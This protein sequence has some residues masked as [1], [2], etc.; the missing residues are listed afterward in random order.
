MSDLIIKVVFV[1]GG[2]LFSLIVIGL[3]LFTFS[4]L[5]R[6]RRKA[7]IDKFN[8]WLFIIWL[9]PVFG[10]LLYWK[11]GVKELKRYRRKLSPD[12]SKVR[13]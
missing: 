2:L 12:F 9:I 8:L 4:D 10:S 1:V 5:I 7:R 13:K 11:Y 6:R 3:P